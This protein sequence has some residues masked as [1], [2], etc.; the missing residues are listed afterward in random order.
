MRFAQ[1]KFSELWCPSWS[2][3]W[4]SQSKMITWDQGDEK[5][6]PFLAIQCLKSIYNQ[7][8]LWLQEQIESSTK[9]WN[10]LDSFK[11]IFIQE[12]SLFS[13]NMYSKCISV[14]MDK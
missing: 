5:S 10:T 13:F 12:D 9:F 1:L 4:L 6:P 2:N 3:P 11:Y 7:T 14:W 8:C